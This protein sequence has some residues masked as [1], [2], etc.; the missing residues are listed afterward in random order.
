MRGRDEG[1]SLRRVLVAFDDSP[2]G[3]RLLELAGELAR[4]FE[5]PLSGHFIEQEGLVEFAG[6]P[7]AKEVTLGS[8][9]VRPLSRE[10]MEAHRLAQTRAARRHVE[11]LATRHRISC[12]F[13]I[14]RGRPEMVIASIAE[15]TDLVLLSPRVGFLAK[16]SAGEL[17]RFLSG[18]M[19]SGLIAQTQPGPAADAGPVLAVVDADLPSAKTA[20]SAARA[21]ARQRDGEPRVILCCDPSLQAELAPA[22][23][24][25]GG[26]EPLD[27]KTVAQESAL[28]A[29]V[30]ACEPS[31]IVLSDSLPEE[32]R[33]DLCELGRA[34][35]V[36]RTEG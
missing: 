15:K 18:S 14:E 4:C 26:D 29:Q 9:A 32:V 31:L 10:R 36:V 19:A 23:A 35:L 33:A 34:V 21:I 20:I 1:A 6:L 7:I 22:I 3:R 30:A 11:S 28:G 8:A 25:L 5:A 13:T 12:R 24:D 27:V 17:L 2:Q 16:P